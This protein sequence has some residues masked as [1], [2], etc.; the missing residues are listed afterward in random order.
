M[1]AKNALN[2][3]NNGNHNWTVILGKK[4]TFFKYKFII[5]IGNNIKI[6][7]SRNANKIFVINDKML[8]KEK[9]SL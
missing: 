3:V 7:E 6:K 9:R 1:N 2:F 8:V 5:P 4:Y